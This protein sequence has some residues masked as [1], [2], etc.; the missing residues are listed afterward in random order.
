MLAAVALN[1]LDQT[2][3]SRSDIKTAGIYL[4]Y[5]QASAQTLEN[6]LSG[7]L[8]QLI[9][10]Q[11]PLKETIRQVHK[12][13]SD[14]NTR[15]SLTEIT[16]IV[17]NEVRTC[18]VVCIVVDA[19]D[20]FEDAQRMSLALKLKNLGPM[21][22]L[23]ITSRQI[24]LNQDILAAAI[25]WDTCAPDEDIRIYIRDRISNHDQLS[26][27]VS[28]ATDLEDL[29]VTTVRGK[30]RDDDHNK[31]P[32]KKPPVM[33]LLAKLQM[34]TIANKI[35]I[36]AVRNALE[37][38]PEKFDDLYHEAMERIRHQPED[39]RRLAE[40]T[41]IWVI[42]TYRPLKFETIRHALA[43]EQGTKHFDPENLSDNDLILNTCAGLVTLEPESDNLRLIHYTAQEYFKS[44]PALPCPHRDI[45]QT[46][47]TYLSYDIFQIPNDQDKVTLLRSH[48]PGVSDFHLNDLRYLLDYASFF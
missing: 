17:E 43:I 44:Y 2:C 40:Q 32:A 41:L 27:F 4:D 15:P 31:P 23:M 38:L 1:H 42:H 28:R 8:A 9:E 46:C 47:V 30:A 3:H 11:R 48:W 16:D 37:S 18:K 19:L 6:V 25:S 5:R 7:L 24:T 45:V 14:Q 22:R 34:D 12:K 13:Y 29:I 33:F 26:R 39:A 36:K 35:S 21:I 10:C 20:E